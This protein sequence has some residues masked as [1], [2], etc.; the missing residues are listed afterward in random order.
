MTIDLSSIRLGKEAS[1][2]SQLDLDLPPLERAKLVHYGSWWVLPWARIGRKRLVGVRMVPGVPF[3]ESPVVRVTRHEVETVASRPR[4]FVPVLIY[5]DMIL[6]AER[7]QAARKMSAATWS[8]FES[9]HRALGGDDLSSVRA[10]L[11]DEA[12]QQSVAVAKGKAIADGFSRLDPSPE[13]IAYRAYLVAATTA[14]PQ[15]PLPLPEEIGSWRAAAAS[16][17]LVA[18]QNINLMRGREGTVTDRIYRSAWEMLL[19]PPGLD[20]FQSRVV[21]QV[22]SATGSSAKGLPM[23]AARILF[24]HEGDVPAEWLADPMWAVVRSL[25]KAQA[26]YDAM[27]HFEAAKALTKSEQF[28][29]VFTALIGVE[30]WRYGLSKEPFPQVMEAARLLAE[31]QEWSEIAEAIGE[32]IEVARRAVAQ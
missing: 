23:E 25:G 15:A 21:T 4:F 12:L 27:A 10:V 29:R 18:N 13:T 30:Y 14:P 26:R 17:A 6:S 1:R 31:E 3:S 20:C 19:Q 2:L 7:W 8:E 22:V 9:L 24:E 32:T 28:E 11:E 16:V 5:Q